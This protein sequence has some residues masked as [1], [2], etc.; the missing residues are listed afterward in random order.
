MKEPIN[1]DAQNLQVTLF[2]SDLTKLVE[3]V[4][5]TT[6]RTA[7]RTILDEV[8]ANNSEEDLLT[9]DQAAKI[10]QCSSRTID[11]LRRSGRLTAKRIG[12]KSVRFYR[13]EVMEVVNGKGRTAFK[14]GR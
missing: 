13:K 3:Q 14:T 1:E 5:N 11:N 8:T 10:L 4:V 6:L 9:R 7:V 12:P 2:I